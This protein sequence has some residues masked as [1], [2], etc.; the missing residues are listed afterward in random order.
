MSDYLT[1]LAARALGRAE[2][3]QPRLPSLFEAAA[4]PA[5]DEHV[6]REA[7]P[8]DSGTIRPAPPW[9]PGRPVAEPASPGDLSASPGGRPDMP[10]R[11][12]PAPPADDAEPSSDAAPPPGTAAMFARDR[13]AAR[14]RD[15]YDGAGLEDGR[16]ERRDARPSPAD[17]PPDLA[18]P[19]APPRHRADATRSEARDAAPAR[20]LRP[21]VAVERPAREN[22]PSVRVT[23]GRVEVRAV[24]PPPPRPAPAR[25][26]APR[27]SLEE[28]V[29]LRDEGRR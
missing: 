6:I 27:L 20:G 4:S 26:R 12:R 7:P 9:S 28:Y 2:V 22:A 1:R 21:A 14:A 13:D 23:I 17:V 19:V 3:V 10:S 29:R 11:V 16:A 5:L 15:A 8:R 18:Q 25:P 24:A